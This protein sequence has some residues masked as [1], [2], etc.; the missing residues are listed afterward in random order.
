M[1]NKTKI[2]VEDANEFLNR[3]IPRLKNRIIK[4]AEEHARFMQEF[5]RTANSYI[6]LK[7]GDYTQPRDEMLVK[8]QWLTV[9]RPGYKL[10][11]FNP[12]HRRKF[13]TTEVGKQL[14]QQL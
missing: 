7:P 9:R 3:D 4:K 12:P 2:T 8:N 14:P 13:E 1:K 5:F 6:Y 10:S 11:E